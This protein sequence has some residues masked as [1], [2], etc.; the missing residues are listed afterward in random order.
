MAVIH[1]NEE[2]V[3]LDKKLWN[4]ADRLRSNLAEGKK[5]GDVGAPRKGWYTRGYLPHRDESQLIQSITFRLA[6]SLPQEKLKMLEL[7]L[8]NIS[9]DQRDIDRRKRIEEWLDAGMGCLL[10]VI[11]M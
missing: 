3:F 1:S 9:K 6:D 2:Q 5:G 10:C 8:E 7:E 4:A 11:L